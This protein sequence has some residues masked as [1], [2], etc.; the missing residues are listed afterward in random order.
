MAVG[1]S[2]HPTCRAY[3]PVLTIISSATVID[4]EG[5][6]GRDLPLRPEHRRNM[7]STSS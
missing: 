5:W 2:G 3:L 7:R 4:A 6:T 1:I